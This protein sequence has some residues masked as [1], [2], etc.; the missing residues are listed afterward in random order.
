MA[1]EIFRSPSNGPPG[2][3]RIKRKVIDTTQN[4]TTASETRR[5]KR[6]A[7]MVLGRDHS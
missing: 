4:K 1:L 5:L 6:T 7:S 3:A 2:E